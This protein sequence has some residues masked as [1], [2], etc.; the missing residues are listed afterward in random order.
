M[1]EWIPVRYKSADDRLQ[2]FARDYPADGPTLLLMHGLTRNSADFEPLISHLDERFRLIVPDQRGRGLSDPDPD[3]A[4]YR[5]DVYASDMF[6]LMG[7]LDIGRAGLIGTSMGGLMAMMM[8]TTAPAMVSCIVLNDIGPQVEQEGLDRIRGYVGPVG[9]FGSWG[10][11]AQACAEI[12][13]DA[14]PS[15]GDA[16]WLAFAHRTCTR[17]ASGQIRFAY[18]PAIA[19]QEQESDGGDDEHGAG[20][21]PADLWPLW[22]ALDPLPILALRGALSDLLSAQTVAT[23]AQRHSGPFRAV[24][25]AGVG[26]APMLDE[27]AARAAIGSFLQRHAG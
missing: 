15:W 20:L 27:A 19:G 1:R 10:E 16:D 23:M 9:T 4:N 25:I 8:G 5:L 3:P 17:T 22:D 13:G 14:F 2:L 7:K 11:A 26:H 21:V 18:D 24:E 6:A 12:N